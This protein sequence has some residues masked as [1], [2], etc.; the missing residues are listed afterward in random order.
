MIVGIVSNFSMKTTGVVFRNMI[1][2]DPCLKMSHDE[3][4]EIHIRQKRQRS[5]GGSPI[6]QRNGRGRPRGSNC[7]G[8]GLGGDKL[9][10]SS[11]E[12]IV[13]G[14]GQAVFW[15]DEQIAAASS[16]WPYLVAHYRSR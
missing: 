11:T 8:Y 2:S 14:M 16:W 7:A 1:A 12:R 9:A 5:E 6:G 4:S 3:C 10:A 13:S 15:H